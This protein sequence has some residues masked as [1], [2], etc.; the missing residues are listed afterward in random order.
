M[1]KESDPLPKKNPFPHITY[2]ECSFNY[3][4]VLFLAFLQIMGSVQKFLY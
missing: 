3:W 4:L 2:N 1:S